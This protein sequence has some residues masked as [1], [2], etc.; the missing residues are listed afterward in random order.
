[1]QI[2][3]PSALH[4][5]YQPRVTVLN[6][7]LHRPARL[8]C[9]STRTMHRPVQSSDEVASYL[10]SASSNC[11]GGGTSSCL[12]FTPFG[13]AGGGFPGRPE[14]SLHLHR[15]ATGLRVAPNPASSG[16][17]DGKS[18]SYPES[19]LLQHH[20][21]MELRVDS[22]LAPSAAPASKIRVAPNL[23]STCIAV[24]EAPSF[25]VTTSSGSADGRSSGLPETLPPAAPAD[26]SPSHPGFRILQPR[27]SS[28]S[29]CPRILPLRLGQ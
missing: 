11:T 23:H 22:N 14:S 20:R 9:V 8:N 27:R 28:V 15:L 12:E 1:M 4:D 25:P 13:F 19:P 16:S 18:P 29:G 17:T 5:R 6:S 7:I 24:D 10:A 21:Q 2:Q 3:S 26:G